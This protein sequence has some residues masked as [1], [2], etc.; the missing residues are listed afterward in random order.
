MTRRRDIRVS[1]ALGWTLVLPFQWYIEDTPM[2]LAIS[3]IW[4]A[5]LTVPIGYLG[6]CIAR[7]TNTHWS[8]EGVALGLVAGAATL[9][10]GLVVIPNVFGLPAA[11]MRDWSAV[12][13]GIVGGGALAAYDGKRR[14]AEEIVDPVVVG[15]VSESGWL[16]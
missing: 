12:V 6:V 3:L 15:A 2:E 11:S 5:C 16:S 7:R 13:L 1:A 4:T 9:I 10:A 8:A 14:R